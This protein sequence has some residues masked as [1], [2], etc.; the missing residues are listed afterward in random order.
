MIGPAPKRITPL[1]N[2]NPALER[3]TL[4]R[5]DAATLQHN[6]VTHSGTV[7]INHY[8]ESGVSRIEFCAP[9][10]RMDEIK[11]AK[12]TIT[13]PGTRFPIIFDIGGYGDGHIMTSI[14]DPV[15]IGTNHKLDRVTFHLPNFPDVTTHEMFHDVLFEQRKK[16]DISWSQVLLE[17]DGWC[18]AIQPYEN[19]NSIMQSY[20][21]GQY[22]VLSAVGEITKTDGSQFKPKH[23]LPVLDAV[24]VF[25]SFAFAAWKTPL[26]V[27]RSNSVAT[28]SV[29]RFSRNQGGLHWFSEGWLDERHGQH[30]TEAY[31]GFCRLWA[32]EQW[33][34]PSLRLLPG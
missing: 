20:C 8:W 11:F 28:R 12:A 4:F 16:T 34:R 3:E 17:Y 7:T 29:Q 5:S 10:L 32:K 19:I 30:L 15:C 33:A 18:I 24:R 6:G 23:V 27:V 31:P 13:A 14:I 26:F 9:T 22:V 25:L 21:F 2:F 1:F